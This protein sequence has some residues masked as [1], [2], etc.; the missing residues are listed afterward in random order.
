MMTTH[1]FPVLALICLAGVSGGCRSVPDADVPDSAGVR[2]LYLKAS[3]ALSVFD[4]DVLVLLMGKT[5][6]GGTE[7]A[8][9]FIREYN[10]AKPEGVSVA[11]LD[12]PPAGKTI[13]KDAS[14][15]DDLHYELDGDRQTAEAFDFFYYPTLFIFDR[16]GVARFRGGCDPDNV[17]KVVAALLAEKR[18]APKITFNAAVPGKG[19]RAVDFSGETIDGKR[20]SFDTLRGK[21]SASL[22]IFSSTNCPFSKKA[23]GCVSRIAGDFKA[24]GVSVV[25]VNS[26]SGLDVAYPF[27]SKTTPGIPV[28][29][30]EK[31][32]IS[33]AKYGVQVVP[34]FLAIDGEGVIAHRMPFDEAT[35]REALDSTL[36][37]YSGPVK[38]RAK[39]AG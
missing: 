16:D 1:L 36:G 11:R 34:F 17:K 35:A 31:N 13:G 38:A 25:I 20:V 8:M 2:P 18:G 22:L 7:A 5:G 39:G 28:L 10:R 15:P 29:V 6:C 9:P 33:G 14:A 12:V 4:G 26:G 23:M 24:K 19:S 3:A 37:L 21:S 30:D 32:E 27:Y